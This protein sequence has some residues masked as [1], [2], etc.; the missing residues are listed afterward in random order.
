MNP[1]IKIAAAA[2]LLSFFN[3]S[4][5][6]AADLTITVDNLR[7]N[8]GQVLLCVFSAESSDREAFPDCVKGR[9]VRQSKSAVADGK[10]VV[11]YKGLKDGVYSVAVIHDGDL[12]T[13]SL[14]APGFAS[15]VHPDWPTIAPLA[16][17]KTILKE[18]SA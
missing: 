5:A 9:P 3:L 8:Q 15:A 2:A 4:Q 10:V 6:A 14:T 13:G 7:S 11:S 18:Q 16:R 12:L 17:P 1:H